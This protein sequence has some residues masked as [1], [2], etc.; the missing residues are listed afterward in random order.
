MRV[1]PLLVTTLLLAV[2]VFAQQA[3]PATPAPAQA[4]Q[5]PAHPVT[6]DQVREILQLTHAKELVHQSERNSFALMKRSFPPYMPQDVSD[7]LLKQL[8]AFDLEPLAV[9]AYQRHLSTEDAAE[10][11]E[12]YKTPA[13]Q[14]MITATPA[15]EQELQ[16]GGQQEGIKIAR[17]VISAHMDEIKAAAA[18]Y[19]AEHSDTPKITAPN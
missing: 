17:Q 11:I 16:M 18:K 8:E 7:D 5:P 2:P 9:A 13:G 19:R 4:D 12:F 15:I 1:V 6:V 10:V 14:R 3:S